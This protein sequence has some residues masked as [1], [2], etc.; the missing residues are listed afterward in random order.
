LAKH[1]NPDISNIAKSFH[2]SAR[3][4]KK[5][6]SSY[7]KLWCKTSEGKSDREGFCQESERIFKMI[8]DRVRY[9]QE[10]MFP[11]VEKHYDH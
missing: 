5:D 9:E 7:I 10:E 2:N 4:I 6:F 11:I 1:H 3:P 8:Q